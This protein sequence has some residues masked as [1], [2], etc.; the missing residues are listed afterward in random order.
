MKPS[1]VL[2]FTKPYFLDFLEE[3]DEWE[4]ECE[5]PGKFFGGISQG[6]SYF[7][8][9]NNACIESFKQIINEKTWLVA[10]KEEGDI[11]TH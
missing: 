9:K 5:K 8:T 4:W 11:Q 6:T 1:L 2:N 3:G 7:G 10:C